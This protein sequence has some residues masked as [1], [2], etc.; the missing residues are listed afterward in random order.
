MKRVAWCMTLILITVLAQTSLADDKTVKDFTLPSATDASFIHLSDYSGKVV[1]INWWRTSCGYSQ[2]ESSRLV[3]LYKKYRGQGLEIL[4]VSDDTPDTVAQIP[5]YLKQYKVTWPI[6][7]ND[8]GEFMREVRPLGQGETPGNYLVS[9]GGKVTYL[10]LDRTPQ[11]W[12]QLEETVIRL[13]AEPVPKTAAILPRQLEKAPSFSLKDLKGKPVTLAA[14][15]GKPLVIN[16]FTAQT[17]DW[18]GTLLSQLKRDF[19]N[20]GLQVVG[21]N[22]YDNDAA[23]EAC[24]AKHATTYPVL[25]GDEA[26]Q[27]DWIGSSAGWAIFFVTPD[28]VIAKKIADSVDNGLE[29]SVF[30]KYVAYLLA[31]R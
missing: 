4:G 16:F 21:I 14:F 15:A 27:T 19:A 13:L 30:P 28:G 8:Q 29:A 10:G 7:L 25:K 2:R 12:Q 26:T 5:A 1:L 11:S 20:K 9:R 23:I 18:T 3:E 22:L 31:E 6:G 17:C 24:N